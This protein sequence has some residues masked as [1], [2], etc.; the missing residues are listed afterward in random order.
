MNRLP[1]F[2]AETRLA[3][4]SILIQKGFGSNACYVRSTWRFHRSGLLRGRLLSPLFLCLKAAFSLFSK[5]DDVEDE[6]KKTEDE[7]IML[8]KR[9]KVCQPEL[10]PFADV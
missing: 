3:A 6:S 9:S 4:C 7:I 10:M 5:T 1:V 2:K 8:L